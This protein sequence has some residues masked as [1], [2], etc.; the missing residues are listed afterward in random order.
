M[1]KGLKRKVPRAMYRGIPSYDFN[2]IAQAGGG[3][4]VTL[5]GDIRLIR[6]LVTLVFGDAFSEDLGIALDAV[7]S[8]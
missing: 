6:R 3:D 7:E 4:A 5:D 1:Q 8:I 2:L